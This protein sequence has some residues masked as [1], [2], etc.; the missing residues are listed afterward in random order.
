M[1]QEQRIP[2]P[3][4]TDSG[5]S[6]PDCITSP[7]AGRGS[8]QAEPD[9]RTPEPKATGNQTGG[10][11]PLNVSNLRSGLHADPAKQLV[12]L[13][14][15]KLPKWLAQAEQDA[16]D[17]RMLLEDA[18]MAAH[19]SVDVAAAHTIH[20][21]V[22][23]FRHG[24]IVRAYIRKHGADMKPG[25]QLTWWA[26]VPKA[27]EAADKA[28]RDLKLIAS[29]E[30]EIDRFYRDLRAGVFDAD[31]SPTNATAAK[32]EPLAGD[33]KKGPQT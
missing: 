16:L 20:R 22:A 9:T 30:D 7:D 28:V 18:V 21:A 29:K 4:P 5:T 8:G 14:L 1:A 31:P 15:G 33:S 32:S 27:A 13:A 25:D 3:L 11:P 23:A 12:R 2:N 6:A 24:S 26:Q 17:H 10:A 19:G